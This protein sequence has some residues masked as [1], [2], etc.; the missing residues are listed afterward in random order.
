M[1]APSRA[2]SLVPQPNLLR[3]PPVSQL[4]PLQAPLD[5]H[6]PDRLARESYPLDEE[7][8]EV[9]RPSKVS[10]GFQRP[11]RLQRA[12]LSWTPCHPTPQTHFGPN[13]AKSTVD[14]MKSRESSTG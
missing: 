11:Y 5:P 8:S 14:C 12:T 2:P 7:P 10:V 6:T 9:K 13:Y 3:A 1:Q 4:I